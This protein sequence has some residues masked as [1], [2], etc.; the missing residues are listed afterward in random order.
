MD[1]T[2]TQQR[3]IK[4]LSDGLP[5]TREEIHSLLDDALTELSAVRKHVCL[6][7]AKLAGRGETILCELVNRRICYRHVRLLSPNGRTY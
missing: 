6:V 4:L 2:P 1:L 7:R 5:H 3:I